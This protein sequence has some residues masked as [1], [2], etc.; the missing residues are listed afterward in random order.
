MMILSTENKLIPAGENWT[1]IDIG[2]HY[3]FT[4]QNVAAV[5][6]EYSFTDGLKRG[7]YLTPYTFI[8]DIRQTIYVRFYN[9][10]HSGEISI[11]WVDRDD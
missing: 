5:M 8:G 2:S 11:T 10:E 3:S 9:V 6:M 7:S 1:P 4:I